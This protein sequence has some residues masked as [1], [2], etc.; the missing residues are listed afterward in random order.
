[1]KCMPITAIRNQAC[2]GFLSG[3]GRNAFDAV[4]PTGIW[5]P[6]FGSEKQQTSKIYEISG[7]S[8]NYE[9]LQVICSWTCTGSEG[10]VGS[11]NTQSECSYIVVDN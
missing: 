6:V 5:N 9:H 3:A 8:G 11:R 2:S 10:W 1:M 4:V 7:S